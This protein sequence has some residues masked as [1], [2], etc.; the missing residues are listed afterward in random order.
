MD[1]M[2]VSTSQGAYKPPTKL[3]PMQKSFGRPKHTG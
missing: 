1:S 3:A 2:Y